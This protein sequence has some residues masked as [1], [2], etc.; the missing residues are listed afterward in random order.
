MKRNPLNYSIIDE[1]PKP[2]WPRIST[3]EDL[4]GIG[5]ST[6]KSSFCQLVVLAEKA[7]HSKY[8]FFELPQSALSSKEETPST[9]NQS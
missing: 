2:I 8:D 1:Y 9:W 7:V 3:L 6:C 5:F 4:F